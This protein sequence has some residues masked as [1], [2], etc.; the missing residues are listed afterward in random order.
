M[1][2]N[3]EPIKKFEYCMEFFII[4]EEESYPP[5]VYC[6]LAIF[7]GESK[8]DGLSKPKFNHWERQMTSLA[9]LLSGRCQLLGVIFF[10]PTTHQLKCHNLR[11]DFFVTYG[12]T[13]RMFYTKPTTEGT[14]KQ[15]TMHYLSTKIHENWIEVIAL[16][17]ND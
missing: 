9:Y 1:L 5:K 2:R 6:L 3:S 11:S 4:P 7:L 13:S 15:S 12:W 17:I 10:T 16:R 14:H 8:A